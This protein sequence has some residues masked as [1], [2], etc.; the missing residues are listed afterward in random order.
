MKRTMRTTALLTTTVYIAVILYFLLSCQKQKSA[1]ASQE[2]PEVNT[3]KTDDSENYYPE[4]AD[5]QREK[6]IYR[7][8]FKNLNNWE[9]RH[10]SDKRVVN[11]TLMSASYDSIVLKKD[12]PANL[13]IEL[14]AKASIWDKRTIGCGFRILLRMNKAE[15]AEGEAIPKY[16]F[17]DLQFHPTPDP[18]EIPNWGGYKYILVYK[19]F[20]EKKKD[21]QKCILEKRWLEGKAEHWY[22][23]KILI[24]GNTITAWL[25]GEEVFSITDTENSFSAGKFGLA[26]YS[27]G[28]YAYFKD[29]KISSLNDGDG[30]SE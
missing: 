2:H 12:V 8:T 5:G 13:V 26:G 9:Y 21:T 10:G 17:Y 25:D 20:A 30:K 15:G 22:N 19:Q 6:V 18:R 4:D 23:V 7:D 1:A 29:L 11:N 27:S 16:N 14:K 28:S 3:V 24:K